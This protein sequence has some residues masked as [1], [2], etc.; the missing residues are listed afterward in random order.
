MA[1]IL[2]DHLFIFTSHETNVT[3]NSGVLLNPQVHSEAVEAFLSKQTG[4]LTGIGG[5]IVGRSTCFC[6]SC[7]YY[8]ATLT[9]HTIRLGKTP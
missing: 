5:G 8:S 3:T 7:H 9:D 6:K 1:D 2:Q 4:P